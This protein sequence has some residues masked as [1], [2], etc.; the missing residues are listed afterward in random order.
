MISVRSTFTGGEYG[1]ER[2]NVTAQRH[3]PSSLLSWFERMIRTLRECPE[4]GCGACAAVDI[5][6]ARSVLVHRADFAGGVVL[7]VHN[8]GDDDATLDLSKIAEDGLKPLELFA[9]QKYEPVDG[10]LAEV[11]VAGGGYRWIRLKEMSISGP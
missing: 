3:D 2:V 10:K 11:T 1:Y 9:D 6:D 7:F 4:V 8:L 5:E